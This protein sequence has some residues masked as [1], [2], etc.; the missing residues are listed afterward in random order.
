LYC[1]W[2]KEVAGSDLAQAEH[3]RE[4][5]S[6]AGERERLLSGWVSSAW[7]AGGGAGGLGCDAGVGR[8]LGLDG[9]FSETHVRHVRALTGLFICVFE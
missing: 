8:E 5:A 9:F 1:D 7:E 6:D 3:L 2:E 4:E